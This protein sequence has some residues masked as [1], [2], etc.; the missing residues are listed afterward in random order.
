MLCNNAFHIVHFNLN[1]SEFQNSIL[2]C[3]LDIH[4]MKSNW[5]FKLYFKTQLLGLPLKLVSSTVF[6]ISL[7]D[8]S[9]FLA[10]QVNS[11]GITL[12]SYLS[13]TLHP[14]LILS[15][16][17]CFSPSKYMP[18]QPVHITTLFQATILSC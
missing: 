13:H 6:P 17:H 16:T 8:N 7:N 3:P 11:L 1:L 9:N 10:I 14:N 4:S 5:H 12:D 2:N 15:K 18:S